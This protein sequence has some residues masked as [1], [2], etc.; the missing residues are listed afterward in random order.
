MPTLLTIIVHIGHLLLW[1]TAE[2]SLTLISGTTIA[3]YTAHER[4]KRPR[5]PPTDD[6]GHEFGV[7]GHEER[8]EELASES[9]LLRRSM[10]RAGLL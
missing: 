4:V 1:T 5:S 8:G 9:E 7:V 3:P 2:S 6:E 10:V